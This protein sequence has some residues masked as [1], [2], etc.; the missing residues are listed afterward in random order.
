MRTFAILTLLIAFIAAL[1]LPHTEVGAHGLAAVG[2]RVLAKADAKTVEPLAKGRPVGCLVKSMI[3]ADPTFA[4]F[5]S[6]V[7]RSVRSAGNLQLNLPL[8]I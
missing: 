6:V 1:I 4:P 3:Q 5:E 8:L 2:G 7:W